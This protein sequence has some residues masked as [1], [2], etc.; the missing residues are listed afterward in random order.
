MVYYFDNKKIISRTYMQN[1]LSIR[2]FFCNEDGQLLE[3]FLPKTKLKLV[4][5]WLEIHKDELM[6]DWRL[7]LEGEQLFKIDPLK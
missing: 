1:L 4:A 2:P 5:A 7:A 6:A 3:G